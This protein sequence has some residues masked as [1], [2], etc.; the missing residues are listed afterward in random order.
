MTSLISRMT[1]LDDQTVDRIRKGDDTYV[2]GRKVAGTGET[3]SNIKASVQPP[4]GQ[5]F[6]MILQ[7]EEGKR[8]KEWIV[9]YCEVGTFRAADDRSSIP[10]DIVVSEGNNYEV[11]KVS[12]RRGLRLSHDAV[13]AV[14]LET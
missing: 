9:V 8:T 1:I 12:N 10:A 7:F 6:N 5:F 14:R 4:K 11:Q 3:T 13:L 2:A